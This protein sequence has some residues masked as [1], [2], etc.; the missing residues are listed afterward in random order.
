VAES[1]PLLLTGVAVLLVGESHVGPWVQQSTLGMG[2]CSMDLCRRAHAANTYSLDVSQP[3][4]QITG[5]KLD[6]L[7]ICSKDTWF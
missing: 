1:R 4:P 6:L 5:C 3:L 2:T 7:Q